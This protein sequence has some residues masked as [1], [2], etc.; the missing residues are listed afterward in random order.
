MSAPIFQ[1]DVLFYQRLLSACGLY[2][3]TLDGSWGPNTDA[4]DQAFTEESN[5]LKQRL[6]T[7]DPRSERCI[8]TLH[9]RAQE[10]ARE[11][12][13]AVAGFDVTVR[14]ISGTRTYA[15][16]DALFAKGRTAPGPRV[17]NAKGGQSNH[18]FGIAWDIGLFRGGEYLDG[19]TAAEQA[20][21]SSVAE[22]K[23][24][25]LEWGGDWT[26]FKDPPH[27]Q[28]ANGHSTSQVRGLFEQG[29]A[30]A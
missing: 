27:Y 25:G 15:Q 30:Y 10:L 21:Y 18:N 2:T 28:V 5:K 7:F 4:A 11:F 3:D 23:P 13:S 8:E 24:G 20:L 9:L 17:T 26:S 16:Q 19:D 1:E 14:I 29:A 12:M 22:L 6:G